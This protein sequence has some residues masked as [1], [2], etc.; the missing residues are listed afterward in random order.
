ML[1]D[2]VRAPG[3]P[4]VAAA[5][6]SETA[7]AEAAKNYRDFVGVYQFEFDGEKAVIQFSVRNDKLWAHA[8]TD[9]YEVGE[10]T[11]DKKQP[12]LFRGTTPHG[13][14]WAFEFIKEPEGEPVRCK[15]I[16]EDFGIESVGV[17]I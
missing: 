9:D 13:E 8:V 1:L 5:P 2:S 4:D 10:L 3:G 15:F 12:T 7:K 6:G 17:R 11:P 16:D 14:H